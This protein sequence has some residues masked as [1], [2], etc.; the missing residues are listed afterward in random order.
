MSC[1]ACP[2]LKLISLKPGWDSWAVSRS[3]AR[4]CPRVSGV[5]FRCRLRVI[6]MVS[7][8]MSC[9]LVI[10]TGPV[11]GLLASRPPSYPS[12]SRLIVWLKLSVDVNILWSLKTTLK[13]YLHFYLTEIIRNLIFRYI[14][15]L[16]RQINYTHH[17]SVSRLL[18]L[19]GLFLILSRV[20]N[21]LLL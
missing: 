10:R 9:H 21:F 8:M 17:Y 16:I 13:V 15:T 3:G 6:V 12:S 1:S 14:E 11:S 7:V 2:D 20:L 19:W 18:L 4:H 5:L